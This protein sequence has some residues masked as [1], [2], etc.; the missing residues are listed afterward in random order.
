MA[1]SAI[2]RQVVERVKSMSPTG[3]DLMLVQY[4]RQMCRRLKRS[5]GPSVAS[6]TGLGSSDNHRFLTLIKDRWGQPPK[7]G[8]LERN[9]T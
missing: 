4:G 3:R 7:T 1:I 6:K 5:M 8:L 9:L 2:R